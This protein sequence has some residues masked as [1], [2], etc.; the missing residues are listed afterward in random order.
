MSEAG[1]FKPAGWTKGHNFEEARERYKRS[2]GR[3]YGAAKAKQ[4]ATPQR[5]V[6]I[7][8]SSPSVAPAASSI[9]RSLYLETSVHTNCENPL[10][11]VPDV[12]DS[13]LDWSAIMFGKLPYLEHEA[14]EYMGNDVEICFG[15][16]GD[17][18][19]DKYPL[20]VR[21]FTKGKDLPVRM[22]ELII[23]QG[24]GP[25]IQESYEL[26]A[27]YFANNCK[28]PK[29]IKP[30]LVFIGDET[31]YDYIAQDHAKDIVGVDIG[32]HTTTL[33]VMRELQKKFSVYL[34]RKPIIDKNHPQSAIDVNMRVQRTWE[35]YLGAD[36]ISMLP[37]PERVVDV[38]F[39]IMAQEAG[40][41]EYF[42]DELKVR[43]LPDKGGKKKVETVMV[44]LD[45]IHNPNPGTSLD[46]LLQGMHPGTYETN[47]TI[48]DHGKSTLHRSDDS[49]GVVKTKKLL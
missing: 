16:I 2:A 33:S 19:W 49:E 10:V 1:D 6:I 47:K 18:F 5:S 20:Q 39:G 15:A 9:D 40:K 26:A 23:E 22:Q 17:A 7:P 36:H 25:P 31:P 21:P 44:S 8:S 43:Q 41:V 48:I 4:P 34:I 42:E 24:G 37:S 29:A 12:T 3:S 46:A 45:T 32:R 14:K 13:M 28:M 30:L 38:I 11:I 27:L 35:R